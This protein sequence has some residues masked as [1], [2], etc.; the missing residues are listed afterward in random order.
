MLLELKLN[1]LMNTGRPRDVVFELMNF[2]HRQHCK[3]RYDRHNII[4]LGFQ[5]K[6]SLLV[7]GYWV[8]SADS[9]ESQVAPRSIYIHIGKRDFKVEMM[10]LKRL[11]RAELLKHSISDVRVRIS[12][13]SYQKQK[14]VNAS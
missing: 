4:Y 6:I 7:I 9:V 14:T 13:F 2:Q 1:W 10:T 3:H 5:Q 11:K 12:M 8:Y